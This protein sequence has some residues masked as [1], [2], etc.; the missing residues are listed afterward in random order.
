MREKFGLII[1]W[2]GFLLGTILSS[3]AVFF[4]HG[5]ATKTF[6]LF[7]ILVLFFV[8]F[9]VCWSIR[10]GLTGFAGFFPWYSKPD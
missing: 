10:R 1:H 8:P 7:L 9:G 2:I 4:L 6:L 3:G 5:F